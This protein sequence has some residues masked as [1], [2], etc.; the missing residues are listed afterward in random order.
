M[1]IT[2]GRMKYVP[3]TYTWVSVILPEGIRKKGCELLQGAR[4][5]SP[6]VDHRGIRGWGG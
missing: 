1:I 5:R 6:S 3:Q 4:E 2:Q